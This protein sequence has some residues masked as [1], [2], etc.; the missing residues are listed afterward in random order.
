L[1]FREQMLYFA[2]NH[3]HSLILLAIR[4]TL[5]PKSLLSLFLSSFLFW[6]MDR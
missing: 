4:A 6:L 2:S 3:R 5:R 1:R